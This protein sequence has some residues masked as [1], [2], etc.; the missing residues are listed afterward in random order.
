MR[1]N[2]SRRRSIPRLQARTLR[3]FASFS[4]ACKSEAMDMAVKRTT[5]ESI[6]KL[7]AEY[8]PGWRIADDEWEPRNADEKVPLLCERGHRCDKKPGNIRAG[9]KCKEC[10]TE[11]KRRDGGQSFIAVLESEGYTPLF[12]ATDYVNART[13]MLVRCPNGSEWSV[14]YD[15]F[16]TP[17]IRLRCSCSACKPEK[18]KPTRWTPETAAVAML[19]RGFRIDPVDYVNTSTKVRGV[20]VKCGHEA[21]VFPCY[22]F[23]GSAA[24]A[25]CAGKAP[26]TTEEYA[27]EIA[28]APNAEGYTLAEG[29]EYVNAGTKI[30]HVCD[31]GHEFEMRPRDFL[32]GKRCPECARLKQSERQRGENSHFFDPNTTE[33]ERREREEQ[34]RD[35]AL[36]SWAK[37]VKRNDGESCRVCGSTDTLHAHHLY[38][39]TASPWL[40]VKDENGVTLCGGADSC[41]NEFHQR[42]GFGDNTPDQFIEWLRGKLERGEGDPVTIRGLIRDIQARDLRHL[43][44]EEC[45]EYTYERVADG[46][47]NLARF[48]KSRGAK[49]IKRR[50]LRSHVC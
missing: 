35:P 31:R 44:I 13:P 48:L 25:K 3:G 46:R 7:L 40:R 36:K 32:S 6:E 37:R 29:V 17:R 27:A 8:R 11:D 33:E 38:A 10:V 9:Y 39:K 1:K 43:W 12:K 21:E 30:A 49:Q 41:H 23:D 42:Y 5:R 22:V 4:C 14:R 2:R 24:C 18:R 16:T 15:M 20:W 47:D 45:I 26:K 19:E 28:A 34:N 50:E